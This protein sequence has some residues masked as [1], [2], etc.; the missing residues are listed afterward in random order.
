MISQDVLSLRAGLQELGCKM[1]TPVRI[2]MPTE[3]WELFV[4]RMQGL[5]IPVGDT[6]VYQALGFEFEEKKG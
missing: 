3:T 2:V 5:L 1:S 6:G 4:E